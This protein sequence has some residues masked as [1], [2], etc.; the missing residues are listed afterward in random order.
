MP[1]HPPGFRRCCDLLWPR[2]VP[3]ERLAAEVG[4]DRG[5]DRRGFRRV[6]HFASCAADRGAFV[7]AFATAIYPALVFPATDAD[8]GCVF[9]FTQLA[10]V[11]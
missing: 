11:Y 3:G 2:P 7:L 1:S 5:A 4:V 9:T 6:P 10:A 8:V